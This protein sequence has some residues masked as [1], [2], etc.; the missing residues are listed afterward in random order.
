MLVSKCG[1]STELLRKEF[2]IGNSDLQ[3]M[4]DNHVIPEWGGMVSTR[5][6]VHV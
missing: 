5:I 4:I 2:R 6:H 1:L 3:C